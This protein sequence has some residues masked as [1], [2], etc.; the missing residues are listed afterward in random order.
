MS[1]L[2]EQ[3]E[4]VAYE[5][6]QTID[7]IDNTLSKQAKQLDDQEED[8]ADADIPND[9]TPDEYADMD[10]DEDGDEAD[11]KVK[12]TAPPMTAKFEAVIQRIAAARGVSM[13]A[14]A[15]LARK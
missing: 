3:A 6:Q 15:Q 4:A 14:A 5:L 10:G 8:I 13:T 11:N 12:K 9:A 7:A 1:R 2:L